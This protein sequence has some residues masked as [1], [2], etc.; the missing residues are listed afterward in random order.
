MDIS[1]EV[2][3][4]MELLNSQQEVVAAAQQEIKRRA[5]AE[6]RL[7]AAQRELQSAQNTFDYY[8]ETIL[9]QLAKNPA[10]HGEAVFNQIQALVTA[11]LVMKHPEALESVQTL[12]DEIEH[13]TQELGQ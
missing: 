9:D 13:L 5:D 6:A 4:M 10:H 7:Y 1:P 2:K 12:K 3:S 11:I 8:H